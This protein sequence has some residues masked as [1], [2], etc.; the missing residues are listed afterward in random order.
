MIVSCGDNADS[1]IERD[2][3]LGR[4]S[5]GLR[6]VN[7]IRDVVAWHFHDFELLLQD[8]TNLPVASFLAKSI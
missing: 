5:L 3:V 8:K 7:M 1:D 4:W 6:S 2:S